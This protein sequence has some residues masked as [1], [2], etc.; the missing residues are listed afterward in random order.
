MEVGPDVKQSTCYSVIVLSRDKRGYVVSGRRS[1]ENRP[2]HVGRPVCV[3]D[4]FW[5]EVIALVER[6]DQ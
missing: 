5:L 6:N 2:P 1:N 3:K 4:L